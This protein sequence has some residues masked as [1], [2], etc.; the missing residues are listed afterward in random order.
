MSKEVESVVLVNEL[1]EDVVSPKH[2]SWKE[3]F[4]TVS[5]FFVKRSEFMLGFVTGSI[6]VLSS[7]RYRQRYLF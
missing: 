2:S 7:S 5:S 6:L 4:Y 3:R 1:V